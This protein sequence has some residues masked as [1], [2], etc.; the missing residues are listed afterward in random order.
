MKTGFTKKSGRCLVSAAEKDGVQ[1]IAVTLNASDD[2]NDH[3][4]MFEYGF[5][6]VE[7]VSLPSPDLPQVAVSGGDSQKISVEMDTPPTLTMMCNEQD[8]IE[9]L[10]NLPFF[11]LAPVTKGEEIGDVQYMLNGQLLYTVPLTVSESVESLPVAGYWERCGCFLRE[12]FVEL[13]H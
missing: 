2:W 7:S 6:Q 10:V 12:L 4:A 1:L 9:I 8:D 13:F 5:T 11:V 3:I